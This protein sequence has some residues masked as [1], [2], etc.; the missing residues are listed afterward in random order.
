MWACL[1][2]SY[3]VVLYCF[4][5]GFSPCPSPIL[6]QQDNEFLNSSLLFTLFP[7]LPPKP[8]SYELLMCLEIPVSSES[9]LVEGKSPTRCFLIPFIPHLWPSGSSVTLPP[10]LRLSDKI[11]AYILED[12]LSGWVPRGHE[13]LAYCVQ[14]EGYPQWASKSLTKPLHPLFEDT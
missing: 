7:S 3:Y 9:P 10:Q 14:L 11:S 1:G 12:A 5:N 2:D 6:T 4:K 13:E 8:Q